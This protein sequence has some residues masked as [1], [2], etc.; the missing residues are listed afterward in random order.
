MTLVA[1][2]YSASKPVDKAYDAEE[3]QDRLIEKSIKLLAFKVGNL[4]DITDWAGLDLE[5]LGLREQEK[6]A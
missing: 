6:R 3:E 4:L 5:V 1:S 2:E